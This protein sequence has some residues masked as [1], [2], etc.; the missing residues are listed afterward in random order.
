MRTTRIVLIGAGSV[1][2]GLSVF[3]DIFGC[4]D[5]AGSTLCLVDIDRTN[6]D[7]MYDFAV[8]LNK[9]TG[10]GMRIERTTDRREALPGAGFVVSSIAIRRCELWKLDFQVP[11][12]HGVRHTLGENGGPGGLFFTMR[13][14]PLVLDIAR[15]MEELCPDAYFLNFSNPESRIVLAVS[16]YTRIRCLGLCHGVFGGIESVAK[17]MGRDEESICVT[18]AGLNHFQ[19]LLSVSDRETG[20]DLYPEIL[21]KADSYDPSFNPLSRKLLKAF[22]RYP[23]CDDGH[24]GEYLP[25]GWESG[26]EGYDFDADARWR[27]ELAEK[28]RRWTTGAAPITESLGESGERVVHAITGVLNDGKTLLESGI[29]YNRRAILNL[30][31]DLAVEVPVVADRNGFHPVSVGS[32][33]DGIARML[34]REAIVQQMSVDA[35]VRGSRELALQALLIDPVITSFDAAVAILDE[36]WQANAPYIRACL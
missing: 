29:V 20:A 17:I 35:A 4:P 30:P 36:L 9:A 5:L 18:A 32:L 1:S 26:E 21:E 7:R 13:T 28:I 23:S 11:R 24:I 19:W 22:G 34:M 15:D 12:K 31:T 25:Y 33:P 8:A 2:F 14:I 27:V 6:L 10:R 3:Q 16:R